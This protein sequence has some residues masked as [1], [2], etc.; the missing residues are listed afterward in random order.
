MKKLFNFR[1]FLLFAVLMLVAT[2]FATYVFVAQKIRLTLFIICVSLSLIFVILFIIFRHRFIKILFVSL[3]VLS[4]P[5]ISI[6]AKSFNFNRNLYLNN[7]NVVIYGK[8]NAGYKLTSTGN[9]E[10]VLD[11]VLIKHFDDEIDINGKVAIYTS[12]ENLDLSKFSAGA[13]L[14]VETSLR[15][16]SLDENVSRSVRYLNRGIVASGYSAFYKISLTGEVNESL[17]D[18][19]HASV[20]NTL[21]DSEMKH[22]DVA[23]AMLF[24]DTSVLSEDLKDSFRATGI[25]HLLAVSG[26]HVSIIILLFGFLLK[27]LKVGVKSNLIINAIFLV[28]YCYLCNFSVSVMR[29]SLMALFALYALLRGKAYDNLSVLSLIAFVVLLINPLEMFNVSFVLSFSAVL[30]I[31]LM[32][33]P[34]KRIFDKVFYDKFSKTLAVNAAVQMGLL[35]TN[36]YYFGRY[37]LLGIFANLIAVPIA[38]FGFNIL[39]VGVILSSVLP[40]MSFINLGFGYLM[41][42]VVRFNSWVAR[43]GMNLSFGSIPVLVIVLMFLFMFVL[44][45]YFFAS[46]KTK[47]VVSISLIVALG[48][49][50]FV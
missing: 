47:A 37:P 34:L 31:I 28:C 19:I 35:A 17:R 4:I 9:L 21:N 18:K 33:G 1:L 46:K 11:D 24:G 25:A 7:E 8:L 44:S 40:F 13:Y 16:Y 6:Y 32:A 50:M 45:D 49:L 15:F 12:P 10:L 30:S 41:D 2:G 20:F 27:K 26:L 48:V 42:V 14:S 23:Y 36:I 3:L 5:F 43:L 38:T 29:A 22:P 39:V